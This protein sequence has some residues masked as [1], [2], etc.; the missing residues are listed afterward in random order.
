M[1]ISTDNNPERDLYFLGAQVIDILKES[2]ESHDFIDIFQQLKENHDISMNLF[3]LA[4]DWLYIL[5][6]IDSKQGTIL[7]CF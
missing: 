6:V 2:G 1:I 3:L 7:R 5:G 4:I